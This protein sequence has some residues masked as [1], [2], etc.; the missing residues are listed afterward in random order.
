MTSVNHNTSTIVNADGSTYF[1][2]V[3]G[4]YDLFGDTVVYSTNTLAQAVTITLG[5]SN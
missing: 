2:P 5:G 4:S 3:A 1:D